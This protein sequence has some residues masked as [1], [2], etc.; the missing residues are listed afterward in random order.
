MA[1][2]AALI[3]RRGQLKGQLTRLNT[4]V[5]DL[6][7]VELEQLTIR[8]EKANIVWKDF[9]E[10]QTQIEEEN[11]MSTENE[12]YS[13]QQRLIDDVQKFFYLRASLSGEAENCVQCMQ[14]T[15]ENYHKTWKSLVD[16]YSN[17][18]VLIK[19]HTK[20]LFNLE[21]VK[22][23]SAERLRKLHGSLSGHFK[24]LETLGKNPRSWGSLI[25][26]LITTKLD[27]ITLEK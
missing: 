24:A 10:V 23:E 2:M 3:S 1:D 19:I 17:K 8:R 11:G 22:D 6:N 9:E 26:Y 15:S 7:G 21:P 4:Y 14:T 12:T 18:R 20:S 27:P 16:R 13:T 5:K 25:L